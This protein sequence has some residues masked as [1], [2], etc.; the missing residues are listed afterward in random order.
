MFSIQDA[1]EA[2]LRLSVLASSILEGA[3]IVRTDVNLLGLGEAGRVLRAH[4]AD[5]QALALAIEVLER[6][7]VRVTA[8]MSPTRPRSRVVP[9]SVESTTSGALKGAAWGVF[10]AGPVGAA[11]GS[12]V[13]GGMKVAF[14][15]HT[16]EGEVLKCIAGKDAYLDIKKQVETKPAQPPKPK[17]ARSE[18]T[19]PRKVGILLGAGIFMLPVVFSWFVLRQGHTSR[20]RA[21]VAAWTALWIVGLCMIPTAPDDATTMSLVVAEG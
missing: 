19:G 12:M 5:F 15:L 3:H 14:E 20:A 6:G 13:G 1:L 16:L 17:K 4:A 11:V 21:I 9:V 18:R 7:T 10:L 8:R 2:K